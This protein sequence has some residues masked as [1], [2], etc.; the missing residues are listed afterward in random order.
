[1]VPPEIIA[2]IMGFLFSDIDDDMASLKA[3]ALVSRTFRAISQRL[4]FSTIKF[5]AQESRFDF[6][7]L[8]DANPSIANYVRSLAYVTYLPNPR[9]YVNYP[10]RSCNA[11]AGALFHCLRGVTSF[12][13]GSIVKAQRNDW[14]LL[15]SSLESPLSSFFQSNNIMKLSLKNIANLPITFFS[16]FPNLTGLK[17]NNVSVVDSPLS[18]GFCKPNSLVSPTAGPLKLF[19]LCVEQAKYTD[20][21]GAIAKLLD[22]ATGPLMDS[23]GLE[24]L[25]V[26]VRYIGPGSPRNPLA[27]STMGMDVIEGLLRSSTAL[28]SLTFSGDPQDLSFLQNMAD[29]NPGS[30]KTLKTLKLCYRL[31]REDGDPYPHFT[32][33]LQQIS[34]ENCLEAISLNISIPAYTRCTTDS[35]QWSQLDRVLSEQGGFPFLRRVRLEIII[36]V[37]GLGYTRN[38]FR[39]LLEDIGEH[40]FSRLRNNYQVDFRF[41]TRFNMDAVISN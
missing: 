41:D 32:K 2:I 33:G 26:D 39:S 28:K 1:M 9:Q 20:H 27:S 36:G 30:M 7:Q 23:G 13:F 14:V 38:E 16:Y 10:P 21:L 3:C 34:G 40:H 22:P 31:G 17:I 35:S 18:D 8:L 11:R 6:E 37:I 24:E 15:T 25:N 12:T 19:S 29:L 5:Q 4:I